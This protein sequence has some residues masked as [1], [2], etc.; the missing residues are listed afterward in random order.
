MEHLQIIFN[1]GTLVPSESSVVN[2]IFP[3]LYVFISHIISLFLVFL[4]LFR[5][6]WKPTE[7]YLRNRT[8]EIQKMVKEAELKAQESE[9]SLQLANAKLMDSKLTA[10][11]IIETAELDAENKKKKIVQEA[12]NK[13]NI[14]EKE[15]FAK[16]RKQELEL[17]SRKN[18]EVSK[19]ALE[20]AE[21]FLLKKIDD[22]ENKKIIDDIV[23]DLTKKFEKNKPQQ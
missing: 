19:L 15:S 9:K 11:K 5:L 10:A 13:A 7:A 4:L 17:E 1:D 3:N 21:T 2:Q 18:L 22:E 8:E 16:I 6:A 20:T 14:I 23:A 12:Q